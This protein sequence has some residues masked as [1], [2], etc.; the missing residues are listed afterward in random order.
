MMGVEDEGQLWIPYEGLFQT[1]S[2]FFTQELS[3]CL[4]GQCM[5]LNSCECGNL[6]VRKLC[7][8]CCCTTNVELEYKKKHEKKT[9]NRKL[10]FATLSFKMACPQCI[11]PRDCFYYLCECKWHFI[12]HKNCNTACNREK[13]NVKI[14]LSAKMLTDVNV[15][16]KDSKNFVFSIC[17]YIWVTF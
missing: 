8:V 15:M 11:T 7:T 1:C 10:Y 12:F 6:G 9:K 3:Y 4:S 17:Q 5:Q 16:I 2:L 13:K 14:S